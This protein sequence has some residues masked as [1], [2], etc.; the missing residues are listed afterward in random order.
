MNETPRTPQSFQV[1]DDAPAK[2][3]KTSTPR[4]PTAVREMERISFSPEADDPFLHEGAGVPA[5]LPPRKRR[6]LTLPRLFFGALS[7]LLSLAIGLWVDQLIRDL[8]TR[9]DWLGWTAASLAALAL[10]ALLAGVLR[11]LWA[12]RRLSSV[13]RLHARGI[14]Q[15]TH[16]TRDGARALIG[17][18]SGV[19]AGRPEAKAGRAEMARLMDDIIDPPDLLALGEKE[20]LGPLDDKAIPMILNSA[21]RVSVVTAVSPRAIVDLAYVL[22]ES[23]RLIR[24]IAELYGARPGTIGFI[25][26]ARDVLAHLA[27]TGSIAVGDGLVQQVVGHGLAARLSARLGEGVVNGLMTVRIGIAALDTVRPMPFNARKRPAMTDF[28]SELTRLTNAE[29]AQ[30]DTIRS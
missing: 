26:L 3:A 29:K 27:V 1:P 21:K 17:E 30:D 19:L 13:E 15:I 25:R 6:L 14:E 9:S 23:G 5:P 12:L 18:V 28:L 7:L 16:P 11:E 2:A 20:M 4:E 24:R 22:F 8:F 10:V